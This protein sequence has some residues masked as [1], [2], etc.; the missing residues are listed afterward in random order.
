MRKPGIGIVIGLIGLFTVQAITGQAQPVDAVNVIQP[1]ST[2]P[3]E[4]ARVIN[5]SER[6]WSRHHNEFNVDLTRVWEQMGIDPGD[7]GECRG[8]CQATIFRNELEP[9]PGREVILKLTRSYDFC[10]Y[11]IFSRAKDTPGARS[12]WKLRGYIDHDFNRYQMARHRVVHAFGKHWLVIRGQEGSGSGYS[13]YGE[14]W[15]EV[16]KKGVR[17]V[18]HYSVDGV[19]DPGMTGLKWELEGR[20]VAW[21]NSRSREPIV[22]L[23][24]AVVYTARGTEDSDFTRRFVNRRNAYYVWN[25]RAREFVFAPDGSTISEHEMNLIANAE[26]ESEAAEE[27]VKLGQNTFFSSPKGFV[28]SGF[29]MFLRLN[30]RELMKIARGSNSRGKD[31]LRE[32]VKQSDDIPEK[33][34]LE[35]A[36]LD[37]LPESR[38]QR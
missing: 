16:D 33:M 26:T 8:D 2:S 28:G 29:E 6:M 5:Q 24:F 13:L 19:T 14:T 21:T 23:N 22:R 27:G 11:L 17:P 37:W 32:F 35:K 15:F 10:R 9:T 20:A 30:V 25:G 4:I 1:K 34:A 36:L 12:R 31:W 7:F 3:F 38:K 18:L